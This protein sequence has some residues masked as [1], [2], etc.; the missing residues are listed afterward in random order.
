MLGLVASSGWISAGMANAPLPHPRQL[1][2][3]G[4]VLCCYRRR[5]GN[6]LAGWDRAVRAQVRADD[7]QGTP[8][9]LL[10]FDQSGHCC[11][12][13]YLLPDTDFLAWDALVSGLPTVSSRPAKGLGRWWRKI[14]DAWHDGRWDNCIVR[15]HDHSGSNGGCM[16]AASLGRISVLGMKTAR[17][18]L[19]MERLGTRSA[20]MAEDDAASG[21]A[22]GR[23]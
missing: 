1:S 22:L 18:I 14:C 6:E 2:E 20:G 13:L 9:C 19:R 15:L 11:W 7:E 10:F 8:E 5:W 4:A 16:L 12:R 21:F 3:L 17:R 23:I